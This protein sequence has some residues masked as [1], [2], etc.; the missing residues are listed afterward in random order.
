[1][2]DQ[3]I[4]DIFVEIKLGQAQLKKELQ[5]VQE[6]SEKTAKQIEKI[7][8][9]SKPQF[10]NTLLKKNL[11]EIIILR[12][13]LKAKLEQKISLN[14]DLKSIERTRTQLNKVENALKGIE[15]QSEKGGNQLRGMFDGGLQR[16]TAFAAKVG[17]TLLVVKK[18]F[19]FSKEA[20][21]IKVLR[22]TFEALATKEGLDAKIL[23]NQLEEATHGAVR[24][25]DL[26]KAANRGSFLGVD[27]KALP[28]LLEF[29]T[30]RAKQ[31]GE[32]I[33][34]L[35]NS[36]VVGLGRKSP[37]ILDNLGLTMKELDAAIIEVAKS[38]GIVLNTVD[39]IARATYLTDA[40]V[41][42]AKKSISEFSGE[43][44]NLN[45]R[46]DQF[47]TSWNK[48]T[49]A[50]GETFIPIF[51]TVLTIL[52]DIDEAALNLEKTLSNLFTNGFNKIESPKGLK[53]NPTTG[54]VPPANQRLVPNADGSL[55]LFTFKENAKESVK[56][57]GE[58]KKEIENLVKAQDSLLP[59][60][61]DLAENVKEV[62]RLTKLVTDATTAEK[63][64]KESLAEKVKTEVE[65]KELTYK[66]SK[67][68]LQSAMDTLTAQL[69][70]LEK[71]KDS[72]ENQKK[73]VEL[74]KA[75]NKL[76]EKQK[77]LTFEFE[78]TIDTEAVDK[79]LADEALKRAQERQ[80][81]EKGAA[82]TLTQLRLDAIDDEFE[83]RKEVIELEREQALQN[84]Y[85][86]GLTEAELKEAQNDIDKK[87]ANDLAELTTQKFQAGLSAA[88]SIAS[89]ISTIVDNGNSFVE[90]LS[91]ALQIAE[92]IAAAIQA[93]K[94]ISTVLGI[95]I[96]KTGGEF[97]HGQKIASYNQIPKFAGGG[98]FNVPS[99]YTNDSFLMRVSND[100]RVKV[101][102]A[103]QVGN[104]DKLLSRIEGRLAAI[105]QNINNLETR[106]DI[107]NNAPDIETTVKKNKRVENNLIRQGVKFNES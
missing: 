76:T 47:T 81:K 104:T 4:D 106:V 13:K 37:L 96:A 2:P 71:E 29:A 42:V 82:K 9:K 17:A 18:L 36:I 93:V 23:F 63:K 39:E 49:N 100:E 52:T 64:E 3:S 22:S 28:T 57:I 34:Y 90:S 83:K 15:T 50:L 67:D 91:K 80:E 97:A 24:E 105:N 73:K 69:A 103:N 84:L 10:N 1:M 55:T 41:I 30:L 92:A 16:I 31:T 35:V 74:L 11:S 77:E 60:S 62:E 89:S 98:E 95:P 79:E 61:K 7:F 56:S 21:S 54:V 38:Q 45:T 53:D 66:L 8:G 102:P 27:M 75:I 48:V 86:L 94:V 33:D 107:V 58:L 44:N 78:P 19:D 6:D 88:R 14:A 85:D 20:D 26:L 51:T 46:S 72:T 32:E 59:G 40:A 101:T 12:D 65:L 87:Y 43:V 99:K 68:V 25:I 70:L 5:K